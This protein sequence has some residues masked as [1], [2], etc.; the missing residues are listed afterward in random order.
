MRPASDTCWPGGYAVKVRGHAR[1][2]ED[3]DFL[4]DEKDR[5]SAHDAVTEAGFVEFRRN[6]LVSRYKPPTGP[7]LALDLM[8]LDGRTFATMWSAATVEFLAGC[9]V[10][11][12]SLDHII[13]MKLHAMKHDRMLRGL[14]DLVGIVWLARHNRIDPASEHLRALCLK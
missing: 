11:V 6:E 10:H 5:A 2:T 3:I 4:I 14:D 8:P 12:P 7:L 1:G 9:R 13:A